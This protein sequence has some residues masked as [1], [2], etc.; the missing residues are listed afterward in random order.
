MFLHLGQKKEPGLV[1][2]FYYNSTA[3]GGFMHHTALA[4][5]HDEVSEVSKSI[6]SDFLDATDGG[7][8][9]AVGCER[10]GRAGRE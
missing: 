3:S 5:R 4:G 1:G 10:A 7:A 2:S 6:R 8:G 9:R